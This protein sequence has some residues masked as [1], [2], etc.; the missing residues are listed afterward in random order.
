MGPKRYLCVLQPRAPDRLKRSASMRLPTTT[1]G[2]D[3]TIELT[4]ALHRNLVAYGEALGRQS[5]QPAVEPA[6][7]IAPMI[8]RFIAT[9]RGFAK[10][11][12]AMETAPPSAKD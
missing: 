11:R 3:L 9:D 8:A 7:L 2:S 4:A 1:D 12:R 10:V 6:R 5:G